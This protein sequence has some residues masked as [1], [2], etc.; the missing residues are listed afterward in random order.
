MSIQPTWFQRYYLHRFCDRNKEI[1]TVVVLVALSLLLK[2]I[3]LNHMQV[4]NPLRAD[5]LQYVMTAKNIA[6]QGIFAD[7]I[8]PDS[9]EVSRLPGYPLLLSLVWKT[10]EDINSFHR[11]ALLLNVVFGVFSIVFLYRI[12][13]SRFSRTV[14]VILSMLLLVNPHVLVM[15]GYVLSETLFQLELLLLVWM[16]VR[17]SAGT[18]KKWWVYIGGLI[19]YAL[20]TRPAFLLF[21]PFFGLF[22]LFFDKQ[23]ILIKTLVPRGLLGLSITILPWLVYTQSHGIPF[24]GTQQNSV[25]L[26][27]GFY[28]GF[29]YKDP[30]YYGF[31]YRDPAAPD[32]HHDTKKAL[33]QLYEWVKAEPVKYI[34][35]FVFG[36]P[37]ALWQWN[38]VQGAGDVFIYPVV[39]SAF[40]EDLSFIILI[41]VYKAVYPVMLLLMLI[42]VVLVLRQPVDWVM[43]AVSCILIYFVCIHSVFFSDPRYSIPLRPLMLLLDAYAFNDLYKRW[44]NRGG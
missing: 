21:F 32:I 2:L 23:R 25:T 17:A 9:L 34:T 28:P 31:P 7:V 13:R 29:I 41:S 26:A 30:R 4:D 43:A 44:L 33:R 19:G 37:L 16:I 11:N 10:S 15:E 39:R 5:A 8:K 6:E 18:N 22:F 1:L 20:L 24:S 40:K 38:S 3:H 35:W 14:S 42:G 36:K 12:G 27:A